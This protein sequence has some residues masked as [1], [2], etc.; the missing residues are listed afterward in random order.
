MTTSFL[1]HS[2]LLLVLRRVGGTL[3]DLLLINV[4]RFLRLVVG[5][6]DPDV[7]LQVTVLATAA[8]VPAIRDILDDESTLWNTVEDR[9]DNVA[10]DTVL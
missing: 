7:R 4:V 9:F 10:L 5:R 8:G 6:I 3:L 1:Q 2:L